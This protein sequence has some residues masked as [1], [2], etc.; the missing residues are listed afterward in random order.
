MRRLDWTKQEIGLAQ[1]EMTASE[2][3]E[4]VVRQF[5][6][7]IIA[8]DYDKAGATFRRFSGRQL[9]QAFGQIV[10]KIISIGRAKPDERPGRKDVLCPYEVE[11]NPG[12]PHKNGT[13]DVR[14]VE[15]QP[16]RW[17]LDGGI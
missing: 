11:W 2:V 12:E 8:K 10:P 6:E 4:A 15:S 9:K 1:G 14:P 13:A 17:M 3:S 5:F 7:F 16:G